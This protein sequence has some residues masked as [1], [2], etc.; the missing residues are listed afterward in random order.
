[1]LEKTVGAGGH[2]QNAKTLDLIL[3]KIQYKKWKFSIQHENGEVYLKIVTTPFLGREF[4]LEDDPPPAIVDWNNFEIQSNLPIFKNVYS[5]PVVSVTLISYVV[6]MGGYDTIVK[7]IFD[8]CLGIERHE[9]QE[10]FYFEGNR[11]Y[12]P[13]KVIGSGSVT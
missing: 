12:D 6:F 13:H 9:A 8:I 11:V 2:Y 5:S 7:E 1:M 3:S 4:H 10:S